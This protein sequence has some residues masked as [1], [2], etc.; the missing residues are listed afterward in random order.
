VGVGLPDLRG[1]ARPPL[2]RADLKFSFQTE[3]IAAGQKSWL[4]AES[5]VQRCE[6]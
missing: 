4:D 3:R 6:V 2:D 5:H 1:L